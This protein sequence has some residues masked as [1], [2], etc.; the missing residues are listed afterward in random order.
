MEVRNIA[1]LKGRKRIAVGASIACNVIGILFAAYWLQGYLYANEPLKQ[2]ADSIAALPSQA[3]LQTV[4]RGDWNDGTV[5]FSLPETKPAAD[6]MAVIWQKNTLKSIDLS[7]NVVTRRAKSGVSSIIPQ[8]GINPR[9]ALLWAGNP[10]A[11]SNSVTLSYDP[12]TKQYT[13]RSV[14]NK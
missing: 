9:T 4:D 8:P 5:V 6:W 11:H 3:V 1:Y 14:A 13:Y 2:Q 7:Q 10:D 12:K